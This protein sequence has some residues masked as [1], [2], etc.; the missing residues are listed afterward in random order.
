MPRVN[1]NLKKTIFNDVYYPHL[2]DYSRRYEVYY[3]GAG[4][5]KSVFIAQKLLIKAIRNKRKIL[6]I[7]KYGTTLKDSVF[8]L[9][10]DTLKKWQIY[11]YCKINLL[12]NRYVFCLYVQIYYSPFEHTYG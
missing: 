7:R 5:G 12:L 10:I 1:L 6:V 4:S 2:L 11:D 9:I 3:G 8:Q